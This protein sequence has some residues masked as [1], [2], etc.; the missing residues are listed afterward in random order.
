MN[1]NADLKPK[2]HLLVANLKEVANNQAKCADIISRIMEQMRKVAPSP[3]CPENAEKEHELEPE[4]LLDATTLLLRKS[5]EV[6]SSLE[7]VLEWMHN[8]F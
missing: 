4:H 8:S 3:P 1:E 2:E 5:K 6:T 7:Y